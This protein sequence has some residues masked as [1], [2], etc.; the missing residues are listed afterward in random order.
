[1]VEK[2]FKREDHNVKH[3]EIL[4]LIYLFFLVLILFIFSPFCFREER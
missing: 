1:M 3:K 2:K 4:I